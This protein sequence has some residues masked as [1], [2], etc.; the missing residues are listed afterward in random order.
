[1][2]SL[3]AK[4]KITP[5]TSRI[6]SSRIE[7]EFMYACKYLDASIFEPFI[8]EDDCFDKQDKW[9]FLASL[10]EN[11]D[12]AKKRGVRQTVIKKGRCELC[13]IGALT[14]EFWAHRS[15]PEFAYVIRWEKDQLKDIYACNASSGWS[16]SNSRIKRYY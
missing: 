7:F 14:Y 16:T 12:N 13:S 8:E 2:E 9:R 5:N 4:L 15:T 3:V 1:M 6:K 10:K 11:F